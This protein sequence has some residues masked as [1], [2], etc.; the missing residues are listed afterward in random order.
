MGTVRLGGGSRWLYRPA[1]AGTPCG[2]L[3]GVERAVVLAKHIAVIGWKWA[4]SCIHKMLTFK[5]I[6]F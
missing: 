3:R 6:P 5:P 1:P 2:S 4:I